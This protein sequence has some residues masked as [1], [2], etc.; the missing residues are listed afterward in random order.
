MT[1]LLRIR[2]SSTLKRD[3]D[4]SNG[5]ND[6]F[7]YWLEPA[8]YPSVNHVA[9]KIQ[10]KGAHASARPP[11][12]A[13]ARGAESVAGPRGPPSTALQ[14]SPFTQSPLPYSSLCLPDTGTGSS[15]IIQ[16]RSPVPSPTPAFCIH[17]RPSPE[18]IY[19]SGPN[20]LLLQVITTSCFR[21]VR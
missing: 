9:C 1:S 13:T 5:K 16:P 18:P 14:L 7:V 4:S 6:N 12:V 19:L 2:I 3:N 21:R 17:F 8:A 10:R 20:D 11:G 15:P